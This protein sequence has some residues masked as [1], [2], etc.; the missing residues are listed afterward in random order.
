MIS[1]HVLS[2]PSSLTRTN[3]FSVLSFSHFFKLASEK[4]LQT[5][6]NQSN[7]LRWVDAYRLNGHRIA[8]INPVKFREINRCY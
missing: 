5:R 3:R 7:F 8:Q 1:V 4:V 6:Q 2:V